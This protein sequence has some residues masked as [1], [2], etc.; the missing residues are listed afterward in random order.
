MSA[1]AMG[2]AILGL[3]AGCASRAAVRR[4]ENELAAVSSKIGELQKLNEATTRELARTV[5]EVR[6]LQSSTAARVREEQATMQQLARMEASLDVAAETLRGLQASFAKLSGEVRR[7]TARPLASG[8]SR[9]PLPGSESA[10]QLHAAALANMR[11]GEHGQAVLDFLDFIAKFPGYPLAVDAQYWVGEAYYVQ[12]DFRQAL[13]EFQKVIGR[14]HAS[15]R[16]ADALLKI[17]LCYRALHE[18]ARAREAWDALI[19]EFP[20]SEAARRAR[21]LIGVR[22]ASATR[23]R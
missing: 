20:A 6:A 16:A 22:P 23:L 19:E 1:L 11:A 14:P 2:V 10:E 15:N 13:L 17:G 3:L 9:E 18:A 7:L 8:L 21:A 12:R 4:L 5:G